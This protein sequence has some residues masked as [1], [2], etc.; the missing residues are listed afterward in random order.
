MAF[1]SFLIL[2]PKSTLPAFKTETLDK[3]FKGYVSMEVS[4]FNLGYESHIVLG[5]TQNGK[6]SLKTLDVTMRGD[7]NNL[8]GFVTMAGSGGIFDRVTLYLR[9]PGSVGTP[10]VFAI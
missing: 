9:K 5:G 2:R 10:A 3:V 1:D 6:F 4:S 7:S 8:A